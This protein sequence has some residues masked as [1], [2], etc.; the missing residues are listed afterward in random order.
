MIKNSLAAMIVG[1]SGLFATSAS[2]AEIT[3]VHPDNVNGSIVKGGGILVDHSGLITTPGD[4]HTKMSWHKAMEYCSGLDAFGNDD[5][6]LPDKHQLEKLIRHRNEGFLRNSF[7]RREI[8][9]SSSE[10][11]DEKSYVYHPS[12]RSYHKY[13]WPY[14]RDNEVNVR[15][16]RHDTKIH[17]IIREP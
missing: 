1:L 6:Y 16:V 15:C 3:I 11:N 13:E 8:Y 4:A 2:S 17:P 7:D 12:V 14:S 5:W 9:W 10:Y